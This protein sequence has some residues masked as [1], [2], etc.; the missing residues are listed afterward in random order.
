MRVLQISTHAT[1]EPHAGGSIRSDRIAQYLE[2]AGLDVRRLAVCWRTQ[3]ELWDAREP[4]IDIGQSPFWSSPT[5]TE[6]RAWLVHIADYYS[7]FAVSESPNLAAELM[8]QI[9]AA[10][11]DV[12]CLQH[13]WTWPLVRRLPE[14]KS[15]AIRIVYSSHNVETALKQRMLE[16]AGVEVPPDVLGD[17]ASLEH[18]LVKSASFTI[19]CTQADAESFRA[20]GATRVVVASNG[21]DL[22]RRDH[23]VR[24]VPPPLCSNHRFGLF[25]ATQ[26]EPNVGGFFRYLAPALVRLRPNTRIVVAGTVSDGINAEIAA[27]SLGHYDNRRLITLGF[28]ED[29]VL[30]A[31]IAN[32]SALLLP[33]EYGGGSHLKTAEALASGRPIIGTSVSF[34]GFSE[35][36]RLPRVTIVDTPE[37]FEAAVHR[38]LS[39]P[40]LPVADFD[41]PREIGWDTTLSPILEEMY[42][43]R[44][45]LESHMRPASTTS[46]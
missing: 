21:A 46:G 18:D 5:A 16:H 24:V 6:A 4:I 39:T 35:Y 44:A 31:L 26:Y 32:A 42:S 11:P 2:R 23:L 29:P 3:K 19:A 33:I 30:D 10:H 27:R 8:D 43:L 25:I 38:S 37:L 20:W 12:I 34:R 15:G 1:L 9:H 45:A 40:S 17:V 41:L 14:V 7:A 22:K 28:V 36:Q 13:P